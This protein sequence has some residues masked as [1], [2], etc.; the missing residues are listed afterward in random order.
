[1]IR[2]QQFLKKL[3]ACRSLTPQSAGSLELVANVLTRH[4]LQV[5]RLPSGRVD[6]LFAYQGAPTRL[7]FAGHTDVVPPGDLSL[8]QTDPFTAVEKDGYI[9][10]RGA[11]DMKSGVAAMV[12]AIARAAADKKADG[13][14]IFLTTDEEGPAIDGTR[15]F[16]NWWRENNHPLIDACVVGEPT[17]EEVLGDSIKIG[18]RGSLTGHVRVRGKQ[19]HVAYPQQ[20]DNPSHRLVAALGELGK[21]WYSNEAQLQND[22][23]VTTYQLVELKSG[24]GADN[25]TPPHADASFNFRYIGERQKDES[26]EDPAA[27]RLKAQVASVF[28]KH[29][30]GLWE[31]DWEHGALPF[32]VSEEGEFV[33]MFA[34]T[35]E[36]Q[37]RVKPIFNMRGGTSDGRFLQFIS[38]ELLE[39][40][41][42]NATIHAV[43][44]RVKTESVEQLAAIYEQTIRQM[45]QRI[46]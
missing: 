26:A 12:I 32:A 3:I 24:V 40:G 11:A 31:C 25:V 19:T 1:M 18:R 20:G 16:V 29:A 46:G 45:T 4:G 43:N 8:W 34:R 22:E 23:M 37:T 13:V 36:K 41:V 2:A 28:N 14:G 30:K 17:C 9:Y 39:F 6:N 5:K 21:A 7:L 38:K 15:H 27:A 33:Q 35:V 44:E 10:G 42:H